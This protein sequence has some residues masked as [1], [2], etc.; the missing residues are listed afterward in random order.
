[1]S[2][3][4]EFF[5]RLLGY[6]GPLQATVLLVRLRMASELSRVEGV[7]KYRRLVL[8]MPMLVML[9]LRVRVVGVLPLLLAT[10]PCRR[11]H[12]LLLLLVPP[13]PH[14]HQQQHP[15]QIP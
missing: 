4:G 8:V 13:L 14:L 10:Y 5:E 11:L 6:C 2:M 12:D 3:V 9:E 7:A 1:M 15:Q